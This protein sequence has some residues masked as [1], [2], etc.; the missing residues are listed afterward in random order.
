MSKNK[1]IRVAFVKFAPNGNT[2]PTRCDRD[3]IYEGN[4][5]EVLMRANSEDAY[6]IEGTVDSIEYHRWNCTCRVMNLTS[7][8]EYSFTDDGI[9]HRE[10]RLPIAQ[11]YSTQAWNE[12]KKQYYASLPVSAQSEMRQIYEAVAGN[13]G[14]DANLGDGI[15]IKPDGSLDD[16]GR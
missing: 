10:V 16:R 7:E 3:D 2:Y 8:V 1:L 12:K 15:W 13:H 11:V 6:Y 4:E 5:V 9:F 14:K